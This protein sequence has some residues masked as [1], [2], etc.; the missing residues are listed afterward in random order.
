[1]NKNLNFCKYPIE[2]IMMK[3]HITEKM[4]NIKVGCSK[5]KVCNQNNKDNI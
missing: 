3:Q 5:W 2:I 4:F 1:M